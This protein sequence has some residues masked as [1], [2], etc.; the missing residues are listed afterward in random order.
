M[1]IQTWLLRGRT[2]SE[3][4]LGITGTATDTDTDTGITTDTGTDTDKNDGLNMEADTD[5]EKMSLSGCLYLPDA[6]NQPELS[7]LFY[8]SH[9]HVLSCV[10]VCQVWNTKFCHTRRS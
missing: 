3:L 4:E 6:A 5:D 7:R 8:C 9:P 1:N 2:C 10:F